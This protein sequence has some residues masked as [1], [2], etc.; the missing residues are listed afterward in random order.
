MVSYA[1]SPSPVPKHQ[2]IAGNML[3]EFRMQLK[4]CKKCA[5]Y[6]PVD[7]HVAD[8]TILQPDMLV[9][10]GTITKNYLDFPP[11]LVAEILSPSKALKDR[12]T[13]YG[14][15]ESQGIPY[16]II[17]APDTEEAEIYTLQSGAYTLSGK[18]KDIKHDFD[19]GDCNAEI[20][21]REI[22]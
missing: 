19:F 3:S 10:C 16:F 7:Y 8:D 9:V 14:I 1:M 5:V 17:I 4:N 22:W 15:Y 18:G 2:R 21:F 13:K 12:H 11:A 20:D 6:Q